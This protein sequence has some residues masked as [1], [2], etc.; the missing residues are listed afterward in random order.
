MID[1]KKAS[2][3]FKVQILGN[4]KIIYYIDEIQTKIFYMRAYREYCKPNEE[5]KEI[6]DKVKERGAIYE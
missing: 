4:G 5:R 6:L 1:I 2:T 3:V